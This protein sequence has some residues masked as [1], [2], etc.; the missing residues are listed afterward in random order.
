MRADDEDAGRW[1]ISEK[2]E[3]IMYIEGKTTCHA[4]KVQQTLGLNK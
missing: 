2:M 1:H 4:K 3:I